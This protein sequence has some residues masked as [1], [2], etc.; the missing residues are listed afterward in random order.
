M[1]RS[2]RATLAG[3]EALKGAHAKTRRALD[4]KIWTQQDIA[5]KAGVSAKTVQR[6]WNGTG[7]DEAYARSICLVLDVK[8][9]EVIDATP[10]VEPTELDRSGQGDRS[11][12]KGIKPK[13]LVGAGV[14]SSVTAWV[15][16]DELLDRLHAQL[17]ADSAPK[18]M[19]LVGQGGIGKT[20]LA[21]KLVER[22]GVDLPRGRVLPECPYDGVLLLETKNQAGDLIAEIINGLGLDA[23]KVDPAQRVEAI[24]RVLQDQ[25]WLVVLD[26]LED[27]LHPSDH[28]QVGSATVPEVGELLNGLVY[29]PHQSRV[30]LTSRELP[31]DLTEQRGQNSRV[32]PRLVFV[33]E[34]KG[35]NKQAGA[36]L[37]WDLGVV[38]DLAKREEIAL[39]VAGHV[40]VLTQLATFAESE[41]D[42]NLYCYL[43]Q[44]P[45][46]YTD[47]VSKI[48]KVQLARLTEEQC[49]M[50]KRM[51][52][53]RFARDIYSL[54]FFRLYEDDW[55]TSGKFAAFIDKSI[56]FSDSEQTDTQGLIDKL[57]MASL[58][59]K[60]FDSY[61]QIRIYC[62]HPVVENFLQANFREELPLRFQELR[63]VY[64]RI[65]ERNDEILNP[66]ITELL[67]RGMSFL[68][69]KD[70]EDSGI[71]PSQILESI[72]SQD[73]TFEAKVEPS[74]SGADSIALKDTK[75]ETI[76]NILHY[77]L[78]K[79]EGLGLG[80][81][82][83][84]A[85]VHY[86]LMQLEIKRHNP[87][88]A[89]THY[90]T[91]QTLYTQLGAAKDLEKIEQEWN[92]LE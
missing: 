52:V 80:D 35:T 46:L 4:D 32:N 50:L 59:E 33:Q 51:C 45:E 70:M 19:A 82:Q 79:F 3:I 11:G 69:R 29:K 9:V 34:V 71:K 90:T 75:L 81:C 22:V 16:R 26:N 20:S 61:R 83:F 1:G 13:R 18:V 47:D 43:E 39:R 60:V 86:R 14:L 42:G 64:E 85:E 88:A 41:L 31:R 27:M 30:V 7:V 23:E 38:D 76:V 25:V 57:V 21:A 37:L 84:I 12:Q 10:C 36:E 56:Q 66:A 6:F 53:S 77:F 54:T 2:V 44:H 28:E 67:L 63:T 68:I 24:L 5:D 62:L 73:E 65:Y 74:M 40:F 78:R 49:Q 48:L 15:G 58:I 17:I 87:T 8:L 92:A 89:Q 91:A 55:E 72:Q